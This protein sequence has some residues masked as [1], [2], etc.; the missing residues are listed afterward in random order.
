MNAELKALEDN[1]TRSIVPH[2]KCTQTI[3]Y[4]WIYKAKFNSNGTIERHKA[5]LAAE[6][7]IQYNK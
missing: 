7:Y 6:G 3:D 2:P 5:R 4:R 1:N